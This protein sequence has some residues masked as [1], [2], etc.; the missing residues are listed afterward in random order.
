M[1]S[2]I[3][4]EYEDNFIYALLYEGFYYKTNDPSAS[5]HLG[6][7]INSDQDDLSEKLSW[8]G[9]G[10]RSFSI[11]V[12]YQPFC[13]T[14]IKLDHGTESPLKRQPHCFMVELGTWRACY[15]KW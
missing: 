4:D 2:S 3:W 9:I 1:K 13:S 15:K 12:K 5:I 7:K 8:I 11:R 10:Q 6:M 14:S